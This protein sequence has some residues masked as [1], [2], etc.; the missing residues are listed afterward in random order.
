V[1]ENCNWYLGVNREAMLV[2]KNYCALR[3][4]LTPVEAVHIATIA[5]RDDEG[6]RPC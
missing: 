3:D 6:P 2:N 1:V 4:R 5:R